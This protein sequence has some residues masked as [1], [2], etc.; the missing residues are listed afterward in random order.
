VLI[1]LR[2]RATGS[3][4]SLIEEWAVCSVNVLGLLIPRGGALDLLTVGSD[5]LNL[6]LC[7]IPVALA[8]SPCALSAS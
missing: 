4:N 5:D 3:H 1:S 7:A 6:L 8:V 2:G